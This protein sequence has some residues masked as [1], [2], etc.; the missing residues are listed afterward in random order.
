MKHSE[1]VKHL[2]AGKE[3]KRANSNTFFTRTAKLEVIDQHDFD[4]NGNEKLSSLEN[5][6]IEDMI[7][8][9]WEVRETK[10]FADWM[11][12]CRKQG[13]NDDSQL[14]HMVNWISEHNLH[15]F[16]KHMELVAAEENQVDYLAVCENH[17]VVLSQD[18]QG[19][20]IWENDDGDKRSN[21]NFPYKLQ[22]AEDAVTSMNLEAILHV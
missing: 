21:A 6:T 10:T 2:E 15:D 3:I 11:N 12:L 1:A 18:N 7:A 4:T 20:W 5:W 17:D 19:E 22:A 13:W 14:I 16:I 8:Y 9:D